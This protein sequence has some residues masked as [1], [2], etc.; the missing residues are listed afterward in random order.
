MR[1]THVTI[2]Q[3]RGGGFD[4]RHPFIEVHTSRDRDCATQSGNTM[5]S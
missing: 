3:T 5:D 4:D 2:H 1:F